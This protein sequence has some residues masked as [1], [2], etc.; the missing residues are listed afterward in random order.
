MN[1]WNITRWFL[2]KLA[3]ATILDFKFISNRNITYQNHSTFIHCC[4]NLWSDDL[5]RRTRHKV[6]QVGY[7]LKNFLLFSRKPENNL[8]EVKMA[9][10]SSWIKSALFLIIWLF[11]PLVK[12]ESEGGLH[13]SENTKLFFVVAQSYYFSYYFCSFFAFVEN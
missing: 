5:H 6:C 4:Y 8:N 12:G 2:D 9:I 1:N 3:K 13:I 10:Y 11:S 7:P